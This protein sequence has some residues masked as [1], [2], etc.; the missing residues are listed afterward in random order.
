MTQREVILRAITNE[1]SWVQA[2]EVLGVSPGRMRDIR[3]NLE[4]NRLRLHVERRGLRIRYER[5]STDA[6]RKIYQLRREH[7]RFSL[8]EFYN[9]VTEQHHLNVS[10]KCVR[11]LLQ[12]FDH[13][14]ARPTSGA[15]SVSTAASAPLPQVASCD[16]DIRD[17]AARPG[18]HVHGERS[19]RTNEDPSTR[20]PRNPI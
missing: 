19:H 18:V 15:E 3:A 1:C 12:T 17:K 20:H 4:T 8:C 7:P 14:V 10:L 13:N 9:L 6:I 5:V 2:A 11:L 16:R